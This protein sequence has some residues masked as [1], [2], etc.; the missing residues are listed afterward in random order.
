MENYSHVGGSVIGASLPVQHRCIACD[1][2]LFIVQIGILY[3]KGS[4]ENRGNPQLMRF[5]VWCKN[6][7][8]TP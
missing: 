7:L 4:G 8:V 6:R 5:R 1:L 2:M 3:M